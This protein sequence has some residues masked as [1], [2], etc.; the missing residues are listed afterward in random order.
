VASSLV[1]VA[2]SISPNLVAASEGS[3]QL[4]SARIQRIGDGAEVAGAQIWIWGDEENALGNA[5]G[6]RWHG[7][8]G[9][10]LD[11]LNLTPTSGRVSDRS[12]Q[13]ITEPA[14]KL[15]GAQ[16]GVEAISALTPSAERCRYDT[17]E[18]Q[19][20]DDCDGEGNE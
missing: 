10:V 12:T 8:E 5:R 20:K 19:H 7:A 4:V 9:S 11:E 16:I 1:A 14:K 13:L 17:R 6:W 2:G 15:A 3:F 18:K